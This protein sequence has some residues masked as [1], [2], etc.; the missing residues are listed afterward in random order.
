MSRQSPTD[1]TAE[2]REMLLGEQLSSV[3]FVQ[4]YLQLDFDGVQLTYNVWPSV[5]LAEAQSVFGATGYR[6]ALCSLIAHVVSDVAV[7]DM[8]FEV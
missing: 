6:D 7:D 1:L 3:T 4:D 2:E 8:R 5:L